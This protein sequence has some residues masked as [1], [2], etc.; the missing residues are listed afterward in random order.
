MS[1]QTGLLKIGD[2]APD[3][4]A[5]STHG[6][7]QF[8][9]YR[10]DHWV[11]LF[12]HPADFTPVCTTELV[13]F[14]QEAEFFAKHNTRLL[15]VSVDSIHSHIAWVQ[16]VRQT[17][18]IDFAFPLIADLDTKV[19][20][21]FGMIHPGVSNTATVRSVFVIDPKGIIR[22][23]VYYPLNVGR[24]IQ[25]IK[26]V[27]L[28]LQVS[29]KHSVSLPANWQNGE[30]VIIPPPKT[31]SDLN[32]ATQVHSGVEVVDFYLRKKALVA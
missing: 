11:I 21:L 15:G 6:E 27:L 18:G 25:E 13:A 2:A 1:N 7:L 28:A 19:S 14:S 3:F 26:R 4:T 30:Q 32:H 17:Q 31:I 29:D 22:L 20:Q 23:L 8:S 16:N 10:K 5:V 24:N 12:S 9:E